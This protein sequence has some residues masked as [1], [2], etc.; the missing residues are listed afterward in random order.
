MARTESGPVLTRMRIGRP[1]TARVRT[2]SA[3]KTTT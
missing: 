3:I 2:S 1:Y